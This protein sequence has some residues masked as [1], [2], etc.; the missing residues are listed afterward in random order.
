[1]KRNALSTLRRERGISQR[2]LAVTAQVT[3]QAIG[4]IESGRAQPSVAVALALARALDTS[5]ESLFG[6]TPIAP[7]PRRHVVRSSRTVVARI[8][9]RLVRRAL[10]SGTIAMLDGA[11]PERTIFLSGCDV[12]L[13]MLVAHVERESRDTR[14]I[15]FPANNRDALAALRRGTTHLAALHAPQDELQALLWSMPRA[16]VIELGAAEEGWLLAPGRSRAVLR[17]RPR[18]VNRPRGAAARTLLDAELRRAGRTAA[19]VS[20]YGLELPGQLD[21]GR[22]IA[23]GFAD[24]AIGLRSIARVCGLDFVPLRSERCVLVVPERHRREATI[25]A[26]LDALRGPRFRGELDALA[27]YDLRYLGETL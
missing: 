8:G 2:V 1:M 6:V 22:A 10:P 13:G 23:A 7:A 12:A 21:A 14:A 18:I 15:W 11:P 4:A 5:V 24:A 17:S 20:G 9:E 27:A 19:D 16:T 25:G 26:L 3:R